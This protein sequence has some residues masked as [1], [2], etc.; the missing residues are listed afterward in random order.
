MC[1]C[2]TL[3]G[4]WKWADDICKVCLCYWSS[5][6]SSHI[7]RSIAVTWHV[8]F[9]STY[10]CHRYVEVPVVV[11]SCSEARTVHSPNLSGPWDMNVCCPLQTHT[12]ISLYK[13]A[14]GTEATIASAHAATATRHSMYNST[15]Y[16]CP[17][18]LTYYKYTVHF[19]SSPSHYTIVVLLETSV[20]V[21]GSQYLCTWIIYWLMNVPVLHNW[22]RSLSH[23]AW[24]VWLSPAAHCSK[25]HFSKHRCSA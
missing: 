25:I 10:V 19:P 2:T 21:C 1:L 23:S 7:D 6:Q 13:H 24:A 18:L 5:D 12:P 14:I 16:I 8:H 9:K 4:T 15:G 11:K 17:A 20:L 3:G 22:Q